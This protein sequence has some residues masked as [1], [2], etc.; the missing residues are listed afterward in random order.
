MA[1]CTFNPGINDW[2]PYAV[3]TVNE[4]SYDIVNNFSVVSWELAIYR[5]SNV[6]STAPKDYIVVVDGVT[7]ASGTTKIGGVDKKV[8]ASGTR[9]IYH[10]AEGHKTI[11]FSFSLDFDFTWGGTWVGTGGASG[12]LK[13]TDL[14]KS[15]SFKVSSASA[16]MGTAVTFTITRAAT[17]LTHK[18]TLT[19]GGVTTTIAT[20]VGTSYSWTIPLN[21]ADNLPNSISSGCIITCITYSGSIELGK[22]T[23]NMT[24]KVPSSVKPSIDGI[25]LSEATSDIAAKFGAY[26]QNKSALKVVIAASGAYSSTIKTY[27]TKILN[28]TYPENS[29]TSNVLDSSGSVSV[30]VTVT[31]SRGRTNTTTENVTVL[32]YAEPKI[33]KFTAQRCNRDGTDNDEGEYV[34]L[35]YALEVVS[36][37]GKNDQA[38]EIAYKLSTDSDYTTL[39]SGNSHV[40]D[41]TY[42]PPITF[43]VDNSYDFILMVTDYFRTSDDPVTLTADISTAFTLI[44]YHSSGS[45][46]A[47]GKV[48]EKEDTLEIALDVEFIGKVRGAIFDAIYPVDSIYLSYSHV[49]PGDLFG[50]TWVR[51]EN[52]F[53]WGCDD[54]D[55]IGLTGGERDH[56]LTVAEMPTHKHQIAAYKST[57]GNGSTVD[58]YSALA[59]SSSGNDTTGKYYTNGSQSVGGSQP[60]NNMPPYIQVS[61]WRRTE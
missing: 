33:T 47:I 48:S 53:L 54:T 11:E 25:T 50:G 24:L 43:D 31:D 45:G 21:L 2:N 30:E 58:P 8:I 16:D 28:K 61:I 38:Y 57:D 32:A 6:Q 17:S 12:S 40:A 20:G 23:L 5:P 39:R 26:I 41:I 51:I 59:G 36:L 10:D 46:M 55:I 44:D 13:L 3:L 15:S 56:T 35:E 19:L 27:S 22:A 42:I 29:F 37:D 7:V 60:H 1:S 49:Y 4:T 14:Y 34:K 52:R 9:T 18:L